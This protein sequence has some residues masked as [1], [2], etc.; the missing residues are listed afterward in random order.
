M[1]RWEQCIKFLEDEVHPMRRQTVPMIKTLLDK[2]ADFVGTDRGMG[3][4]KFTH[5]ECLQLVNLAPE[6]EV[7]LFVVSSFLF[8]SRRVRY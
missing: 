3:K 1:R 4:Q 5:A 7:A 6:A 8:L 2:L